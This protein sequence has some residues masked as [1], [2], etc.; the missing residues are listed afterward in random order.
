MRHDAPAPPPRD[1]GNH[2]PAH[3]CVGPA[4]PS[5]T[6]V[7]A[8]DRAPSLSDEIYRVDPNGHRVDLSNSPF[9]DSNPVVSSDGKRVAFI[10]TRG[11][12]TGVYEIGIDGHGLVPVVRKVPG[13]DPHTP[14]LAWQPHGRL[15]AVRVRR[16]R[17]AIVRPGRKPILVR[18]GWGFGSWQPWSPDGRVLLVP[19][20]GSKLRA[21]TPQG[22]S[23]WSV[24]ARQPSG[25][26]VSRKGLFAVTTNGGAAAYDEQGRL[27]F[28]LRFGPPLSELGAG[29]VTRRPEPPL[30]SASGFDFRSRRTAGSALLRKHLGYSQLGWADDDRLAIVYREVPC[31]RST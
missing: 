7:F 25:G 30:P 3:G 20:H 8:A 14:V 18:G 29:L 6:I 16:N 13:L 24:P 15:L 4:S 31:Q 11:G 22:H 27:H 26:L 19:A 10:S 12:S 5:S 21:V 17:V 1:R 23:L 2:P 28:K 9:S